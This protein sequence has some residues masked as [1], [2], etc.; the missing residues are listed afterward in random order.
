V[1]LVLYES[2]LVDVALAYAV[3]TIV[4]VTAIGRVVYDTPW[5]SV[6]VCAFAGTVSPALAFMLA[7]R[8]LR[9]RALRAAFEHIQPDEEQ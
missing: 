4:A 8:V 9:R 7:V 5:P 2:R 3:V 1:G 6:V